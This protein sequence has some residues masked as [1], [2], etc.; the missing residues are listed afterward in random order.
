MYN[1]CFMYNGIHHYIKINK[2]TVVQCSIS[3]LQ[4]GT[5]LQWRTGRPQ[6]S[7]SGGACRGHPHSL[8]TTAPPHCHHGDPADSSGP[9]SL[10]CIDNA[11]LS[12]RKKERERKFERNQQSTISKGKEGHSTPIYVAAVLVSPSVFEHKCIRCL[13]M[14]SFGSLV[15]RFPQLA[16]FSISV[17]CP[18]SILT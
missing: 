8:A 10:S 7:L 16:V 5:W 2:Q 6:Q 12:K 17:G 13:I 15:H 1:T 4:T 3:H 11:L 18:L 9:G 14:N